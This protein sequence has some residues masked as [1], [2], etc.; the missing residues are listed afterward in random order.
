[1]IDQLLL[2]YIYSKE[3]WFKMLRKYGW[4]L[5]TPMTAQTSFAGWWLRARKRVCKAHHKAHDSMVALVVW[6]LWLQ[7][8]ARVFGGH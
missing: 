6:Q 2:G 1:M 8:N 4:Q 3:M 5:S 7:R